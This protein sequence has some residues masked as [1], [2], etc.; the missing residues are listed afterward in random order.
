MHNNQNII[1]ARRCVTVCIAKK[2]RVANSDR[3]IPL[4]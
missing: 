1:I 3:E 2:E 4:S